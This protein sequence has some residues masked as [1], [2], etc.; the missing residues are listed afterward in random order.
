MEH[1][2]SPPRPRQRRRIELQQEQDDEAVV[3][4]GGNHNVT[5]IYDLHDD[6][7]MTSHAL[8]GVGHFR[9]HGIACKIFLKASELNPGYKKF[10]TG[11]S[12]TSSIECVQKYFEDEGTGKEQLQFFWFSAA[13]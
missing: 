6:L 3:I 2:D 10:T 8:L 11:E 7:L 4:A 9:Y 12:V 5:T 13:K 1:P